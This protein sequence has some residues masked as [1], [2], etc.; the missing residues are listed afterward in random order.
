[1]VSNKREPSKLLS[2]NMSLLKHLI[3]NTMFLGELPNWKECAEK[4]HDST[5]KRSAQEMNKT[6]NFKL[7][8][9]ETKIQV[10]VAYNNFINETFDWKSE[11]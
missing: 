3:Q 4:K 7:Y 10:N 11:R 2:P 9:W 5:I 8:K 1:M 6:M